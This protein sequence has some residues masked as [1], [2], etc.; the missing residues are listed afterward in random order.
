MIKIKNED[1]I[2]NLGTLDFTN[3][4]GASKITG[5]SKS[6]IYKLTAKRELP[7]YKPCG[8]LIFK[9][10]DLIAWIESFRLG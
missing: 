10:P 1:E 6:K 4:E 9:I 7:H 2:R 8:K 5:L 3:I